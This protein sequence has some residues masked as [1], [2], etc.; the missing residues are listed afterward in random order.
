[1][2]VAVGSD[3][4]DGHRPVSE[5]ASIG[6][7][8]AKCSRPPCLRADGFLGEC[9]GAHSDEVTALIEGL[10]H[11]GFRR[12]EGFGD[13][14]DNDARVPGTAAGPLVGGE[15][16]AVAQDGRD[17]VGVTQPV[18][19]GGGR[20]EAVDVVTVGLGTAQ[21]CGEGA[22]PAE[23]MGFRWIASSPPKRKSRSTIG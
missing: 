2:P 8:R 15:V 6:R 3:G 13:Q 7:L 20:Q 12:T 11:L 10:E 5:V 17:V 14:P 23:V 9:P 22:V 4:D 1:M 18:P 16:Q 19:N 21:L